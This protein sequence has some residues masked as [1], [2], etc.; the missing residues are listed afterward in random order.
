MGKKA[1][2]RMSGPSLSASM[3]RWPRSPCC[4]STKSVNQSIFNFISEN[5]RTYHRYQAGC[6]C[7]PICHHRYFARADCCLA[8][9]FPNDQVLDLDLLATEPRSGSRRLTTVLSSTRTND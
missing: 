5:G 9:M 2:A 8:Y 6:K 1:V 4:R 7:N 3:G